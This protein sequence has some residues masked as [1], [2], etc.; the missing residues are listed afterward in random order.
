VATENVHFAQ[1]LFNF[2]RGSND[3]CNHIGESE[4]GQYRLSLKSAVWSVN[5]PCDFSI[6]AGL[7][8][9]LATR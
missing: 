2:A 5:R 7:I 9:R 3:K 6:A 8:S 1:Q 4:D